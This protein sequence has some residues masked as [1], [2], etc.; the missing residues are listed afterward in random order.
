[1]YDNWS[2]A[3]WDEPNNIGGYQNCVYLQWP[4]K[5][6]LDGDCDDMRNTLCEMLP[7]P[8]NPTQK[9]ETT[10]TT[11]LAPPISAAPPLPKTTATRWEATGARRLK[12]VVRESPPPSIPA[13][14]PKR[15]ASTK[16]L[17]HQ[18]TITKR[19]TLKWESRRDEPSLR[20][21]PK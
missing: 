20:R 6:W 18:Q 15:T 16:S 10:T 3:K 11:S 1:M 2:S 21:M 8:P 19:T 12:S 4:D 7:I 13:A 14:S 5:K 9:P 17:N